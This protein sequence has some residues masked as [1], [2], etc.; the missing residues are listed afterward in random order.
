VNKQTGNLF[1][2]GLCLIGIVAAF[3]RLTSASSAAEEKTPAKLA[4]KNEPAGETKK[5]LDESQKANA[6]R[7][8][9]VQDP[10][11]SGLKADVPLSPEMQD[12]LKHKEKELAELTARLKEKEERLDAEEAR[13]TDRLDE[14]QKIQDQL[15]GERIDSKKRS[16][17]V[18]AKLV[19]TFETMAPK[20]ASGVVTI[21]GDDLAV[22]LLLAMKE[23]KVAAILDTMDP[24]RAMTLSTLIARRR[25]AGKAMT[26]EQAAAPGAGP[27]R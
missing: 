2:L 24:N 7:T 15:S 12:G 20:K 25:P 5:P 13:V 18:L 9:T 4:E 6:A 8:A 22:E 11:I 1:M 10:A 3:L 26:E 14:L 27:R 19:K 21:M 16:D 17:A 23:K